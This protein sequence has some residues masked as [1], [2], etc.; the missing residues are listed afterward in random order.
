MAEKIKRKKRG[1]APDLSNSKDWKLLSLEGLPNTE[2]LP[3]GSFNPHR[4]KANGTLWLVECLHCGRGH[5]RT[6]NELKHR[7]APCSCRK[8]TT[9]VLTYEGVS[10]DLEHW[11]E[12]FPFDIHKGSVRARY[13]RRNVGSM[14]ETNYSDAQVL[15]GASG[16]PK[17][18]DLS[19]VQ[20]DSGL[21]TQFRMH[22]AEILSSNIEGVSEEIIQKI[23]RPVFRKAVFDKV[24]EIQA[25]APST[26]PP[27]VG[28]SFEV[29]AVGMT[30]QEFLAS[31]MTVDDLVEMLSYHEFA[32]PEAKM[33]ALGPV[34]QNPNE[35]ALTQ[36][37]IQ[38][39]LSV[40]TPETFPV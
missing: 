1:Q 35:L 2:K 32:S 17:F 9:L 27:L 8:R 33:D 37:E 6:S 21:E 28:D 30:V 36:Q 5:Y 4:R 40:A 10:G 19:S 23:I 39:L 18:S 22:I 38:L 25:T 16:R 11:A 3:D 7:R 24:E 34:L 15:F 29:P 14:P 20:T 12:A 31:G 13:Y 26:Y